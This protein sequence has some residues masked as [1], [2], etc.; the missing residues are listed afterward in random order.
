MTFVEGTIIDIIY[1]NEDNAYT[2]LELDHEGELLVC[3]GS[4]RES[5]SAFTEHTPATRATEN[6]LRLR[7]WN[8]ACPRE[9]RA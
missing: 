7:A 5:T 9:T 3:V 1:R 2:V 6:S 8:P 4:A